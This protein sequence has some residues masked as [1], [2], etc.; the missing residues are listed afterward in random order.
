LTTQG[1][2]YP[3]NWTAILGGKNGYISP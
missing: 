2:L 3:K 1:E